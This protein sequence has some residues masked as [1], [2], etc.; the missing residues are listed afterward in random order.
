M[1]V[2]TINNNSCVVLAVHVLA[3][4]KYAFNRPYSMNLGLNSCMLPAKKKSRR[5]RIKALET[6]EN[7]IQQ[8]LVTRK[9]RFQLHV[10]I[11]QIT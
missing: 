9:K 5:P 3:Q 8:A 4:T 2:K 10:I 1:N 11:G 7:Y 6:I